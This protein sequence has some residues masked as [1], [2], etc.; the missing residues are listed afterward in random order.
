MIAVGKLKEPA[1]RALADEYL[2]RIARYAKIEERELKDDTGFAKALP[3]QTQIVACEVK[4]KGVTSEQF[5]AQL[6]RW[7]SVGK[8]DVCFLIGGAEGIPK[9]V[10]DA[11]SYKLSL[12]TMTLPHRLARV[13]LLEQ[14][15]RGFSILKGEP[16]ARE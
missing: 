11:A 2:G 4:G 13:L 9:D 7:G 14:I 5:A 12:S 15:Y 6:Q 16:Y 8:G 1:Y 3:M 10:S